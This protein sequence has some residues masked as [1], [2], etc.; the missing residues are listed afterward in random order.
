MMKLDEYNRQVITESDAVNMLYRNPDTD[1]AHLQLDD[2]EKFNS[3]CRSM[4]MDLQLTVGESLDITPQQYHENNQNSWHMP[5]DYAQFDIAKWCLTQCVDDAQLQR[6]GKEL[7]MYQERGML[8]LLRFLR[9]FVETMRTNN[10]VWGVG[11]GSSVASYVLYILG[12][13]RIDS[14]Y[15]DLDPGEFLR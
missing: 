9:Y 1:V 8:P 4:H 6:V 7:L 5:K 15:Y 11:R 12:V 10:I 13:H 3:A 14:M 2:V